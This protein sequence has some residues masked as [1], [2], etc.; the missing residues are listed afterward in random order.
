MSPAFTFFGD[1]REVA[2]GD[3]QNDEEED[4]DNVEDALDELPEV[5]GKENL[6]RDDEDGVA[7]SFG[8]FSTKGSLGGD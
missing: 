1:H 3:I 8:D 6:A 2:A 7:S 5:E 4:S